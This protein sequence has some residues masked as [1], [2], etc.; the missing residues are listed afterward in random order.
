M[1]EVSAG[2][3]VGVVGDIEVFIGVFHVFFS[4]FCSGDL[5]RIF[6]EVMAVELFRLFLKITDIHA[7]FL[8]LHLLAELIRSAVGAVGV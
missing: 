4:V 3:I 8:Y 5:L 2:D 1:Q 7:L 6:I